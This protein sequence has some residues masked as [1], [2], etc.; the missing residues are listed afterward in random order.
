MDAWEKTCDTWRLLAAEINGSFTESTV[1][2]SELHSAQVEKQ[3][4]NWTISFQTTGHTTTGNVS[5]VPLESFTLNVKRKKFDW[6]DMLSNAIPPLFMMGSEVTSTGFAEVEYLYN[7]T[8][9]DTSK[10]RQIMNSA[11]L[12]DVLV[13]SDGMQDFLIC[14]MRMGAIQAGSIFM[15]DFSKAFDRSMMKERFEVFQQ[16]L[17]QLSRLRLASLESPQVANKFEKPEDL[18]DRFNFFKK[19]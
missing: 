3:Y 14:S 4:K 16:T 15:F 10:A 11:K 18:F 19:K 17:D 6:T 1:P 2:F 7:L 5:Y 12:R 13:N 9:N 8:S